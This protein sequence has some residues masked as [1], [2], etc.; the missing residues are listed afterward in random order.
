MAEDALRMTARERLPRRFWRALSACALIVAVFGWSGVH[1]Q[2]QGRP[3]RIGVLSN[4]FMPGIPPIMGLR[5]GIK[6]EGLEDGRD[7]KFDVRSTGSDQKKTDALAAELAKEHPDVI[8][9][10]GEYE[11]RAAMAAAPRTPVVFNQIADPVAIGLVSSVARPGGQLTGVSNLYT[12]LVPKR[13]ELARELMPNLRR[14]LL[15]YDAQDL[16]T[17]AGARKAQETAASLKVNVVVRPVRTQEEAVRELKTA[18]AKDVLLAPA[19]LNL[20]IME[21]LLNLNLYMVAPAIFPASFWVQAGG[22]A[23]YGVDYY[24][25]GVQSARLVAKILRGARPGDLPVE[26]VNKIELTLNS[27]TLKA[28]GVTIP[29]ALAV[30]VDRVFEGI[31]E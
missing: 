16:A 18:N 26:G 28:F 24:A 2:P 9:A 7:V 1:A 30:R 29:P 5:A 12:E 21:L 14:V 27:K 6:A 25:E 11:T 20:N 31:G 22:V 10:I 4:A 3:Y 17:A 23:S 8:V 19:T 15:V 13:L